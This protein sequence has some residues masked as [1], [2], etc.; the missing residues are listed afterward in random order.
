MT[1]EVIIDVQPQEIAI[2]LLEDKDLVEYQEEAKSASFSVGNIY[3]A[4]VRKLMPGLNA[5]FVDVGS[6]KDAF[7]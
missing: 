2:A 4:K 7:L 1:S 5:C 3:A 6:E